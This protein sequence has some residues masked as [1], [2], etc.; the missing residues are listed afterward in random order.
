MIDKAR[1]ALEQVQDEINSMTINL[2]GKEL[3]RVRGSLGYQSLVIRMARIQG[4][5]NRDL[6]LGW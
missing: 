4:W 6:G 3:E 2:N 5:I 1:K